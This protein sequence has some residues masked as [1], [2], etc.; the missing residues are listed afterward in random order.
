MFLKIV[1]LVIVISLL[2]YPAFGLP[3]VSSI[4][5]GLLNEET[6]EELNTAEEVANKLPEIKDPDII[7]L[8]F[9]GSSLYGKPDFDKTGNLVAILK[10]NETSVNPEELGSYLEGDILL[11]QN[12]VIL[13]NGLNS[14]AHR[15]PR[16][17]VPYEIAENF[18]ISDLHII[19]FAMNEYH[20]KTCIRFKPRTNERDYISIVRGNSGC[21]SSVGRIG[22]K[23]QVNLQAPGCLKKPGTVLHELMHVLGFMHEQN[24]KERDSY[25]TIQFQNV[26]ENAVANFQK[27]PNTIAF[28]VGY[29]YGSVMHYSPKAFS[30]NDQPTIVAK[31]PIHRNIMGQR[32]GFSSMDIEKLNRMYNCK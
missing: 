1:Y 26:Q 9:Y 29:D 21:W 7:D 15:W 23:Q 27:A 20:A 17:V 13:K 24:R 16:G 25:V 28:G 10:P 12:A 11:P 2:S 4:F 19:G 14:R 3:L 32:D 30:R 6:E 5:K 8:S 31:N 18:E 22:G